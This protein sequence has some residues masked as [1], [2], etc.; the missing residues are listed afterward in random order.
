[1]K[2][3]FTFLLF[4]FFFFSPRLL[5]GQNLVQQEIDATV[6]SRFAEEKENSS[7]ESGVLWGRIAV[8]ILLFGVFGLF[9]HTNDK[10]KW[11]TAKQEQNEIAARNQN[12]E[13]K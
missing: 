10:G 9:D 3:F 8:A 1:M 6:M 13:N 11:E 5:I 2:Y 4:I 12:G 7:G